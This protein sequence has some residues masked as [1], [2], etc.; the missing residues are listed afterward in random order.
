[1][2]YVRAVAGDARRV[3]ARAVEFRRTIVTTGLAESWT[4]HARGWVAEVAEF[5]ERTILVICARAALPARLD[6]GPAV[7]AQ[8]ADRTLAD[9]RRITRSAVLAARNAGACPAIVA[10]NETSLALL[11]DGARHPFCPVAADVAQTLQSLIGLTIG[12]GEVHR[13]QLARLTRAGGEDSI[14]EVV[15]A[16][17]RLTTAAGVRRALRRAS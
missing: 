1:M 12:G 4:W 2:S 6:A 17:L 16:A 14:T 10:A 8:V 15:G 13:V 3:V 11:I 9:G 7:R 5:V